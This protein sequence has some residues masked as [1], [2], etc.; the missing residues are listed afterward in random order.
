MIGKSPGHCMVSTLIGRSGMGTMYRA[1]DQNFG[2]E[3][4]VKVP[5]EEFAKDAD[6]I[7]RLGREG[8]LGS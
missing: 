7:A 2:R 5:P 8:G 6:R 4:A 3:V 1:E